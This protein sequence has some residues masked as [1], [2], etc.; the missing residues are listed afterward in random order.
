MIYAEKSRNSC[1]KGREWLPVPWK[2]FFIW[3][4]IYMDMRSVSWNLSMGCGPIEFGLAQL[5][6][7]LL[8]VFAHWWQ[9]HW[10]EWQHNWSSWSGISHTHLKFQLSYSGLHSLHLAKFLRTEYICLQGQSFQLCDAAGQHNMR[11]WY[12]LWDTTQTTRQSKISRKTGVFEIHLL[13]KF[14]KSP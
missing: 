2:E 5:P 8:V 10:F 3:K 12:V 13:W 9:T 4:E 7:N 1:K 6:T 14:V 11:H